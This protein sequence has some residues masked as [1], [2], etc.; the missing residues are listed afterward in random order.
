[1]DARESKSVTERL[2]RPL[3]RLAGAWLALALLLGLW[4]GYGAWWL[5]GGHAG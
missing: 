5:G 1:M 3:V 4:Q 2:A